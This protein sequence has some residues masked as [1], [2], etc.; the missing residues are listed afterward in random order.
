MIISDLNHL[1][2]VSEASSVV[3]GGGK[4]KKDKN[5]KGYKKYIKVNVAVVKQEAEAKAIT[6]YGDASAVAANELKLI[7]S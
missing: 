5:D 6:K 2:V 3:G 7:Q 4:G 1:E